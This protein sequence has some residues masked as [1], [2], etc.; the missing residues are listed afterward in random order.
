MA[1]SF[2]SFDELKEFLEKAVEASL[3]FVGE[4][5]TQYIMNE[6]QETIYNA[7]SPST[8][9][10]RYSYTKASSYLKEFTKNSVKITPVV[11]PNPRG[12]PTPTTNKDL[13]ALIEYGGP[14][15]PRRPRGRPSNA[16]KASLH[17]YYDYESIDPRPFMANSTET[18]RGQIAEIVATG[19]AMQGISV[20]F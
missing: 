9:A 17:Q 19:L 14:V 3:E 11:A 2:K 20:S 12:N 18:L 13:T 10:R 1:Q 4:V 8:Y 16:F 7:Y 15:G 5:A 6:A